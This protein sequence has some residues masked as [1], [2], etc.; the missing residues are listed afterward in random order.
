MREGNMTRNCGID[1]ERL[2][3]IDSIVGDSEKDTALLKQMA[4]QASDFLRSHQW[5]D[6]I[7]SQYLGYGVGGIVAVFLCLISAQ[8]DDI[9]SCLWVIVGD[10]PPAYI[11]ANENPSPSAALESYIE[12]MMAWVVA[13]EEGHT[14]EE[15]IPVN[16]PATAGYA[17][18]LRG[19]LEFLRSKI[20]PSMM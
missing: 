5:C 3:S 7:E 4:V 8:S 14:T 1:T 9:D 2:V 19:R 6:D 20:L 10:I 12:E 17:K 13:V 18:E 11:V 15:L 16:A